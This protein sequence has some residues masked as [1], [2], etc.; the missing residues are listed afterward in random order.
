M[1]E[2]AALNTEN[3]MGTAELMHR[4]KPDWW[5]SVE[6]AYSQLTDL[7]A[8]VGTVGWILKDGGQTVG[9]T[10]FRELKGYLTLE[11]ECSGYDDHGVFQLEH[12]LGALLDEAEVYARS[13]GYTSLRNGM[14]SVGFNIDGRPIGDIPEAIRSL[15][16]E[17]VDYHWM[18]AYGFR[19]VGILPNVYRD[20]C[21]MIQLVKEL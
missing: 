11:L 3:A 5:P 12:K 14:S 13:K 17:R 8:S 2:V 15:S 6:D 21:H 16:T 7:D 18:L 4:I 1:M 9:W 10:L 19:V 20:N